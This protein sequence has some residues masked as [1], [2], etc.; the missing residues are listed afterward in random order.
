MDLWNELRMDWYLPHAGIVR[1]LHVLKL[2]AVGGSS[3]HLITWR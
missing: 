2:F 3:V 1:V